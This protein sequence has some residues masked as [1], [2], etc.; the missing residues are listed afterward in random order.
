MKTAPFCAGDP[1]Q[2]RVL[3]IGHDP[4]L[5]I[6]NTLAGH[7][8]FADYYFKPI[9]SQRSER[10]KYKLA[11]AVFD[12]VSTLTNQMYSAEQVVLTNLC[13]TALPHAPKGKTVYIPEEEACQGIREIEDI[14]KGSEIQV[15]LA[16][17]LQVNYWLQ[18]LGFYPAVD[19]F[20]IRAEPKERGVTCEPP[21]YEPARDRPFLLICG[22]QYH[23]KDRRSI[24]PV[25][26]VKHWPLKGRF[27]EAYAEPMEAC[28]NVLRSLR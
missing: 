4:R 22:K 24:F 10:A 13:N 28:I 26:H 12:Y 17:S 18:T 2:A 11:E 5:Q 16:M 14:L 23:T 25:L 20:L 6:S 8:F 15:I 1:K 3:V 19:E 9:S 7:T 27:A 21:Y